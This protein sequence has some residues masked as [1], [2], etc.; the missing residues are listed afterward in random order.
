MSI[1]LVPVVALDTSSASAIIGT[2]SQAVPERRAPPLGKGWLGQ[3][4]RVIDT[5]LGRDVRAV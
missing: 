1:G 2:V 5:Q 3:V 4:F